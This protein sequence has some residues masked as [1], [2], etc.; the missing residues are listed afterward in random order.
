MSYE[1]ILYEVTDNI[2]KITMNLPEMRN[3]LTKQ[4]TKDLIVAI[5]TADQDRDVH[6]IILTGA[7]KVFSAGGN[8]NEFKENFEK[9]V[10]QL[11][12]EGK[13]STE[14]FKL[15][16]TV[17]T[18]IIASVN[19]PALGGGTG[20]VAMSHI[21]IASNKAKLGLTELKL[22]LVPFV[23][24]PWVRRAVGDR[25]AMELMLTAEIIDAERA[26]DYEL[27]HRVV[28]HEELE[29]ETWALAKIVASHSPLAV[30]L[31]MDA[32]FT[33]EQMD[34]MK[35]FDYL[36]TLRLV[37]FQSEDLKEGASAFLEKRKPKWQ[38]K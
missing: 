35:S 31:G 20:L 28:P 16:A 33:T 7:G 14:L 10:P 18:P 36:S 19:G 34:F 25:R 23:I 22:G 38:G 32:Y 2:A 26:K 4:L 37:S 29:E 5:R 17:K 30:N 1:T 24:L 11:H 27:V 9:A 21:A 6:A 13:E 3:P 15:G 12:H 8:L